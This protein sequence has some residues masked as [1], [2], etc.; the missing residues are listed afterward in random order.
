MV[1]VDGTWWWWRETRAQTVDEWAQN[2]S[3]RS[4]GLVL[5]LQ[6]KAKIEQPVRI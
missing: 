3:E 2:R 1:T 6:L 5:S 4:F